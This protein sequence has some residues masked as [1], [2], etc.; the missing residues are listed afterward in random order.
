MSQS[1]GEKYSREILCF[2][3]LIKGELRQ[4]AKLPL[5]TSQLRPNQDPFPSNFSMGL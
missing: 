4:S 3:S 1:Q 2:K 5:N